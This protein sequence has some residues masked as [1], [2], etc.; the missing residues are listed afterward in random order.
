MIAGATI[1]VPRRAGDK[2]RD[3]VWQ[4][5]RRHVEGIAPIVEGHHDEGT[6]NRA[7]A[8]N[9]AAREAG[10]W[11]IAIVLDA[12]TIVP[13]EQI[14]TA[15]DHVRE[16]GELAVAFRKCFHLTEHETDKVLAGSWPDKPGN[17]AISCSRCVVIRRDFWDLTEGFDEMFVGWAG[18]DLALWTVARRLVG[19]RNLAGDAWHLWHQPDPTGAFDHPCYLAN[20]DRLQ[21]YR[22][23]TG[24]QLLALATE[25]N[26]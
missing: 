23:A 10:D 6:W 2:Q 3:R 19:A 26:T 5:V 24:E 4:H 9:R 21:K 16:T 12:D 15:V 22:H 11:Q 25:G 14:K 13:A 18:E 17:P 7:A 1:L 20:I 8:V